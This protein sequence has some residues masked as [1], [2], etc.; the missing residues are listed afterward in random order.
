MAYSTS[1]GLT[2]TFSQ[3]NIERFYAQEAERRGQT[4]STMNALRDKA[5]AG[6]LSAGEQT[7]AQEIA[8]SAIL[9]AMDWT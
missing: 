8:A 4:A 9:A 3:G 7:V 2:V 5:R 1:N 6:T